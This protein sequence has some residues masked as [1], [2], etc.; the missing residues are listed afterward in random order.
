[1]TTASFE[2]LLPEVAPFVRGAPQLTILNA[3]RNAVIEFC[4]ETLLWQETQ[5][6][7][8]AVTDYPLKLDAPNGAEIAKVL[9]VVCGKTVPPTSVDELDAKLGNTDWRSR[10]GTPPQAYYQEHPDYLLFYPNPDAAL[11]LKV[12]LAYV[13]SLTS[14]GVEQFIYRNNHEGLAAGALAKLHAMPGMLWANPA[15]VGF[16][17]AKFNSVKGTGRVLANQAFGRTESQVEFPRA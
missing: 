1:M 7:Q 3:I 14:T 8:A 15:V 16:Y 9:T 6:I 17:L 2:L 13:P 5:T 12:R 11:I 4:W 10:T